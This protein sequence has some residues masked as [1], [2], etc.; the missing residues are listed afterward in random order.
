MKLSELA[1]LI[2]GMISVH[3]DHEV[4]HAEGR[5]EGMPVGEG[6]I[7]FSEDEKVYYL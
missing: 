1:E 4:L 6:S 2:R 5:R 3:G 7:F